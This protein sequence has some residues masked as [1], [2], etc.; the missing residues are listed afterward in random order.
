[1]RVWQWG[2]ALFVALDLVIAGWGLNP[3]VDLQVIRSSPSANSL[4]QQLGGQR[5]YLPGP[6]EYSLKYERFLRFD[7]FDP[8]EDWQNLRTIMLPNMNMLDGLASVNNFDPL[9]PGRYR[10]WMEFL[11]RLYGNLRDG[12][13]RSMNVGLVE[14]IDLHQPLGVRFEPLPGGQPARWVPCAHLAGV[15]AQALDW[16]TN[17][18]VDFRTEVV[19]EGAGA[20]GPLCPAG[21][22]Q[23]SAA[24]IALER[25]GPNQVALH[26]DAPAQGWLVLADTWY[27]GW[28]AWLDGAPAKIW[29]ANYLFRAV[30]LPPGN[31]EVVFKYQPLSVWL[32]G[33]FSL[34]A[35][36]VLA[37]LYRRRGDQV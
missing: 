27:P 26:V 34:V 3:G 35:L 5:L 13:L 28:K 16:I 33:G 17:W 21:Q 32:G 18:Q 31:H 15:G 9:V 29:R 37:G 36:G 30:L 24:Q 19:V 22:A 25:N 23:E 2:V 4:S 6:D 14:R 1:L 11:D 8:G 20:P 10:S 12:L 7:S